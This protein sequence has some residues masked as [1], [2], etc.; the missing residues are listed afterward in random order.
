LKRNA[1]VGASSS[2]YPAG[3]FFPHNVAAVGFTAL[4]GHDYRL[5]RSS[6]YKAEADDGGDIGVDVDELCKALDQYGQHLA[7]AVQSCGSNAVAMH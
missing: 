4:D 3:N 5:S 7:S 6:A 2:S 1:I